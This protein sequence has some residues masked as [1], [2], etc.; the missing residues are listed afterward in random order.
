[1]NAN[2]SRTPAEE[3]ENIIAAFERINGELRLRKANASPEIKDYCERH[4]AMNSRTL[5]VM[6]QA[7]VHVKQMGT[8]GASKP[9]IPPPNRAASG[10]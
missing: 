6:K 7:L 9:P 2:H 1:M 5:Q 10:G 4:I 3:Y 8:S